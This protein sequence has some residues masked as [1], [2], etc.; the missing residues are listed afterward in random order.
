ML[1]T[2]K[3]EKDLVRMS[4]KRWFEETTGPE[5]YLAVEGR[6]GREFILRIA[7]GTDI[8]KA[9]KQFAK[10]KKIKVAK[11]HA[12]FMGGLQPA[13]FHMYA[14]DTVDPDNWANESE[15]SEEKFSMVV[16][17]SGI[18]QYDGISEPTVKIHFVNA[19]KWDVQPFG[20]HLSPGSIVKGLFNV[21]VTELSGLELVHR[22]G[23]EDWFK[24]VR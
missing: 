6:T 18:I 14:P 24:E 1:N 16:S 21:F 4:R 2:L 7:S 15:T 20:G 5:G 22:E 12:A 23:V 3:K 10:D 9:I 11:I 8:Y 19:G 17:M 13:K